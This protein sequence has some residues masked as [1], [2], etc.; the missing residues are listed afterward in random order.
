MKSSYD[1]VIIGSGL[2]GLVAANLLA[3]EGYS[4]CVLEKNQQFGGN[5][6]TFSR[7]KVIF[8]TGVH[9]LGSL[10][11]GQNLYR[12]FAYLGI[13]QELKLSKMDTLF[14][15]VT[16]GDEVKE[17]AYAQ[18]YDNFIET[19][20]KDFPEEKEAILT[21]TDTLK[22]VC[23]NFPLYNL[24]PEKKSYEDLSVFSLGTKEFI[25]SLTDNQ[26]LR[27]VL[28]G[29]NILYA[30]DSKTPFYVHALSVNSYIQS[31]YR[32]IN[33]GSQITKLL[34]K[35]LKEHGGETYKRQEVVSA[36]VSENGVVSVKTKNGK[37]I[38]GKQFI[39]N[40]EPKNTLSIIGEK[41]FRKSYTNRIKTI[42]NGVA[43]FSLY[44][45][46]KPETV[47]YFNKN[48]YHWRDKTRIWD[49]M[50]YT[51]ESWP[52]NYM[53]SMGVDKN[54]GAYGSTLVVLTYM[55]F[56]EV[57]P[58]A[59]TFNTAAETNE[60]GQT[61]EAFKQQKTE[62]LLEVIQDKFPELKNNIKAVYASTPLSYRD[63][64]GSHRGSM[65]GYI[66]NADNPMKA[67]VSPKTKIPN[68]YFT[69]QSM[70]MHGILGVT[71][72]AVNTCS[73]IL[74]RDYLLQKILDSETTL[75]NS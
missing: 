64:I 44:I 6:Q 59:N 75:I 56:E 25:E 18:G 66:K 54:Q 32:C 35:R 68:L 43:A 9:Y 8:D 19:L 40:I 71:V 33:G 22:E 39:S 28:V 34:L 38:F 23:S 47:P 62:R 20:T 45:V 69:G 51:Q 3:K 55:R 31:A 57:E 60:R 72:G 58:W 2:G 1:V 74:G 14:D 48:Y 10:S 17:Y 16:F 13:M 52:V 12:Y 15:V 37:D 27:A 41:H 49:A 73:E 24:D 26:T 29:T 36:M 70:N 11:E 67:M 46:L 65:Y 5:L 4:V 61:Y 21:Y 30:G 50:D 7:D 53:V 63:Y 42:E